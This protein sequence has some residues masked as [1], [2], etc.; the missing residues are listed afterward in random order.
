MTCLT[1]L[2]NDEYTDFFE[3]AVA[4]YAQDNVEAGRWKAAEAPAL[5]R[6]ESERLLPQG[7]ATPDHFIHAIR[8]RPD[9]EAVGYLWYATLAR[10]S[11]TVAYVY[12]LLVKPAQ[13]RRG[14][15]RAALLE[16]ERL[17]LAQGHDSV[18]LHVFAPNQA[19]LALYLALGYEH[20][21]HNMA[22]PIGP[23]DERRE[24][25]GGAAG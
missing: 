20:T 23:R 7:L 15:A 8:A 12:Q 18:A 6:A 13:R 11:S 1:P 22:K 14:H 19:A 4:G 10:G 25:P 16:A 17:A 9:D 3:T 21:S 5:A 2:R 24:R